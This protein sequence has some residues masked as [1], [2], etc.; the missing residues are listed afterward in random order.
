MMLR[1][2]PLTWLD[3]M[4]NGVEHMNFFEGRSTEYSKASTQ[5]LIN[6]TRKLDSLNL[7]NIGEKLD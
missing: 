3:D 5:G 7:E 6:F 2:N 4:L 1:K